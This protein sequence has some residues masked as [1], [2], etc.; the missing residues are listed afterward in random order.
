LTHCNR[1]FQTNTCLTADRRH[2][3]G[4]RNETQSAD[5]DEVF[6][7]PCGGKDNGVLLSQLYNTII[8]ATTGGSKLV[9]PTVANKAF[10]IAP[11]VE[12]G[13][14]SLAIKDNRIDFTGTPV[15]QPLKGET[16]TLVQ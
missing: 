5:F 2:A 15:N 1:S 10:C 8:D 9:A 4:S 16:F 3:L 6:F 12:E 7:A 13:D 11:I 14:L